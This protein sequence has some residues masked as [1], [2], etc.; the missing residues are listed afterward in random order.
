MAFFCTLQERA[1]ILLLL[2][3]HRPLGEFALQGTAVHVEGACC[4]RDI[5][6]MF[7]EYFLQVFPFQAFY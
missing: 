1:I 5:A 6:L 2:F 7:G 3:L 4:R